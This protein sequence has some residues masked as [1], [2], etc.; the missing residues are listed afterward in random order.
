MYQGIP[1][2]SSGYNSVLPLQEA[3]VRSLVAELKYHMHAPP[4]PPKRQCTKVHFLVLISVP[5]LCKMLILGE[6]RWRVY[7]NFQYYFCN[8]WINLKLF[9]YKKPQ[10]FLEGPCLI[11]TSRSCSMVAPGFLLPRAGSSNSISASTRGNACK[12]V[13]QGNSACFPP[14]SLHLPQCLS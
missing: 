6:A 10:K 2:G 8:S 5:C 11:S 13:T 12:P 1:W 7:G 14:T 3:W 9:Q 4:P